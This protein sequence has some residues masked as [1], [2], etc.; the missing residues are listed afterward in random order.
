M[1]VSLGNLFTAV[2]N[3]VIQNPDGSSSLEGASYFLF[4]AGLMFA[5]AVLFIPVAMAF[6]ERTYI[7]HS[8]PDA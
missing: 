2:V 6:K 5:A 4:F 3:T 1:S 8:E 7:Q